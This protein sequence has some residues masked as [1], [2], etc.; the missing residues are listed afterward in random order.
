MRLIKK[1]GFNADKEGFL[2]FVAEVSKQSDSCLVLFEKLKN[3][4]LRCQKENRVN[5]TIISVQLRHAESFLDLL[6]PQDAKENTYDA[7]GA[8]S[9]AEKKSGIAKV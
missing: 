9:R 8:I 5:G 2:A 4:S 7:K 3:L 6:Y 1:N